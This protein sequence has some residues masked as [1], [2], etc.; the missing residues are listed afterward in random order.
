MLQF[1]TRPVTDQRPVSRY[2]LNPENQFLN[3]LDFALFLLSSRHS[4]ER[5]EDLHVDIYA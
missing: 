4:V 5:R 1:N 2:T 3:K